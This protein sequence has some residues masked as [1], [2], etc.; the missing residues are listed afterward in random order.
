MKLIFL[1]ALLFNIV[2]IAQNEEPDFS[3]QEAA[4]VLYD[5]SSGLDPLPIDQN[6]LEKY[7]G[8]PHFNYTEIDPQESWW[9]KFRIWLSGLWSKF[10][11]WLFGDYNSNAFLVFLFKA[12]PYIILGCVILF[13]IWLFYKI[14]PGSKLLLSK[15]TPEVFYTDEEEIIKS[16]NIHKLIEQA[17]VSKDYRLAVRYYF[18]LILK[19]LNEAEIIEYE[20]DKTNS[21]YIKEIKSNSILVPFKKVSMLYEYIW[22]GNFLVTEQE[23]SKANNQLGSLYSKIKKDVE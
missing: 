22:Y 10:W 18:L 14:N 9:F 15:E 6:Q 2:S 19:Q 11:T 1:I 4:E 21:D 13:V 5:S 8:D 20:F 12:L 7:A 3:T 17:L 23:Y 16:K